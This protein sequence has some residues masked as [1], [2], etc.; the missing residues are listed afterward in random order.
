MNVTSRTV[1][2]ATIITGDCLSGLASIPAGTVDAM[3]TD[4]PYCAGGATESA[5]TSSKGMTKSPLGWFTGD[6]MTTTGLVFLLREVAIQAERILTPDGNLL[7]FADWRMVPAL[8]PA[9][10]SSGLRWRSQIIWDKK[11][12]GTGTGFRP[13]Y[14]VILH[15]TKGKA[16]RY[17][18]SAQ[19][20]LVYPRVTPKN[21]RHPTEKPVALLRDLIRSVAPAGG[22]VV[23]P[24]AG[25][26]S[27]GEAALREGRQPILIERSPG[28]VASMTARLAGLEATSAA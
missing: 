2:T 10:E 24:F 27:L 9:L 6:A 23:D 11:S 5:R 26:G 28:F 14:E 21:R 4:P 22:V 7:M 16:P 15:L 12:M 13:R 3:I 25:S 1:G 8:A 18:T 19:N 20:V 17:N